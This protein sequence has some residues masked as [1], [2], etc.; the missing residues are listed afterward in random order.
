[1]CARSAIAPEQ[2]LSPNK[3]F[4]LPRTAFVGNMIGTDPVVKQEQR[5]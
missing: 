4:D 3:R 1:M 5:S 2:I